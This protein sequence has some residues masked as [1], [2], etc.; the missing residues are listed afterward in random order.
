MKS[1]E[2]RRKFVL[3][4]TDENCFFR[5]F[6]GLK[7]K[8]HK[9]ENNRLNRLSN[10]TP[11]LNDR[12]RKRRC[13]ADKELDNIPTLSTTIETMLTTS[14]FRATNLSRL[15]TREND[16]DLSDTKTFSKTKSSTKRW[17]DFSVAAIIGQ[18]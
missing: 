9:N 1:F 7:A 17:T 11:I 3:I 2:V 8:T 12:L 15:R 5:F 10:S 14:A 6:S 18:S 4:F 16:L 13:F